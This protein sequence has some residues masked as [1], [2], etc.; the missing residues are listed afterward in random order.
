MKET[1]RENM[2]KWTFFPYHSGV[3]LPIFHLN[4]LVGCR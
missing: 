1:I 2:K 3:S 4:V